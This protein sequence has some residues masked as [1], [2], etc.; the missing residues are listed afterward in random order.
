M[1]VPSPPMGALTRLPAPMDRPRILGGGGRRMP[2]LCCRVETGP[3]TSKGN[4]TVGKT[5]PK[6]VG[7]KRSGR[8]VRQRPRNLG[9]GG[10]EEK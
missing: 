2:G 1:G 5:F 9:A 6:L 7:G 10:E 4:K 8:G 3:E